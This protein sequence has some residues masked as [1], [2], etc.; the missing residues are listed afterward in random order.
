MRK[1][2]YNL[3]CQREAQT[4]GKELVV[5]CLAGACHAGCG[6]TVAQCKSDWKAVLPSVAWS[7]ATV[8]HGALPLPIAKLV[9]NGASPD[10]VLLHAGLAHGGNLLEHQEQV[11]PGDVV[12]AVGEALAAYQRQ[13]AASAAPDSG[14]GSVAV[15][16][17]RETR[18]TA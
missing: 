14:Q 17:G 18:T 15:V 7:D 16:A 13:L 4:E 3:V 10:Y 12:F 9:L 6:K 11:K 2:W 8:R 1:L 5:Y